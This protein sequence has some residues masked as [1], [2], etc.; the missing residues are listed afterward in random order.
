MRRESYSSW[1]ALLAVALTRCGGQPSAEAVYGASY[2]EIVVEVDYARGAEPYTGQVGG[3]GDAWRLFTG[4]VERLF[5]G[6]DK[7]FE[8]PTALS[9]MQALDDVSGSDFTRDQILALADEHRDRPSAGDTATF[10][11]LFLPGYF[12]SDGQQQSDVLGVS[13]GATGVIAIF[14]PVVSA[15][16]SR[17]MQGPIVKF[18][19]Q[20]TLV[21]ELGHALG[22]VNNGVAMVAPHQDTTNGTHCTNPKCVMYHTNE[23][24]AAAT[25]FVKQYVK[26]A[27]SILFG[28]ECL[29]DTAA[30]IAASRPE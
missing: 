21:H 5:Q 6:G 9:Q 2:R 15:A 18:I 1:A 10:Y 4:N 19:E 12:S 8:I 17:G 25:E 22:L 27:D 16:A 24:A 3:S 29:A 11:V 30:Q 20:S 28:D 7:R 23:G 13:L 26:T 14:K